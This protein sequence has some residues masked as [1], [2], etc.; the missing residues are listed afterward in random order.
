MNPLLPQFNVFEAGGG[1]LVLL[2]W[3][4]RNKGRGEKSVG[5]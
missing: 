5:E 3:L 4:I 2:G 1:E